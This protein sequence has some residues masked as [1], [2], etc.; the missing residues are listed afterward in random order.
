VRAILSAPGEDAAERYARW[1]WGSPQAHPG[2]L[3]TTLRWRAAVS[4]PGRREARGWPKV[5]LETAVGSDAPARCLANDERLL[6]LYQT[7]AA[8]ALMKEGEDI[9]EQ[10]IRVRASRRIEYLI[11]LLDQ[12]NDWRRTLLLEARAA[13]VATGHG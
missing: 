6:A 12:E 2:R 9:R 1:A 4:L 10:D 13:R 7:Y 3:E 8:N 5:L 11:D